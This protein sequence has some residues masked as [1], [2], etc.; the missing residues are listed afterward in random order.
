[1]ARFSFPTSG[2]TFQLVLRDDNEPGSR[3]GKH[4]LFVRMPPHVVQDL[5]SQALKDFGDSDS[6]FEDPAA[7]WIVQKHSRE[8]GRFDEKPINFL[9]LEI[10]LRDDGGEI[11]TIY[12]SFNGGTLRCA[13][14][15]RK[16]EHICYVMIAFIACT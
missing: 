2:G 15:H 10:S 8:S 1:M 6:A 3:P 12:A 11:E 9:P 13:D 16:F 7:S 14:D 5:H 4:N